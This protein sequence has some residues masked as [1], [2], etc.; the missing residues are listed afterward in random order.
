MLLLCYFKHSMWKDFS[1]Y[2]GTF[3]DCYKQ[4]KLVKVLHRM[5]EQI[6]VT[7]KK[8]QKSITLV[9]YHLTNHVLI[10]SN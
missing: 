6:S 7:V 8:S 10:M 3:C 9:S 2:I 5:H 1:C 4:Q